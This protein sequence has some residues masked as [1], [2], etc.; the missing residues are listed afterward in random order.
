MWGLNF[1]FCH[2]GHVPLMVDHP[3]HV[4]GLADEVASSPQSDAGGRKAAADH[5]NHHHSD[6]FYSPVGTT[7]SEALFCAMLNALRSRFV[8]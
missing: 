1:A 4:L 8:R 6:R 2:N 5:S 3:N 7:D